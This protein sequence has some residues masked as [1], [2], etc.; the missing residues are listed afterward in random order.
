MNDQVRERAPETRFTEFTVGTSTIAL[1]TDVTNERAWVQS[2]TTVS[3][4]P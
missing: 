3:V 1:V 4:E 2:D